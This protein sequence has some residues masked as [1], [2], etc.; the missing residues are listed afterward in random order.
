LFAILCFSICATAQTRTL[1]VYPGPGNGL[2]SVSVHSIELE[3]KRL[4]APAGIVPVWRKASGKADGNVE[5]E[6]L[7]VGAFEGDCS[8]E[9]LTRASATAIRA[10]TLADTSVSNNRILPYFR[11]D[12]ARVIRALAPTLQP[13]S[14]PFREAIFG[15]AIARVIAH[16][17]YHIL[18]QTTDHQ[19]SGVA[20]AQ[21]SLGDLTAIRFDLSPASL[22]RM[23]PSDLPGTPAGSGADLTALVQTNRPDLFSGFSG[24]VLP[25]E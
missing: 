11:V 23:Q 3:L 22:R 21:L 2:A 20:K 8:V 13:L 10:S 17:I 25:P 4:L 5:V 9:T 24:A 12:C 7:V 6:R 19:D 16:E 1:E 18:A 15:R 14:V